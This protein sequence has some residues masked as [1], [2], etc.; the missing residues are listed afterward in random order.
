MFCK[1]AMSVP[2]LSF[3][4]EFPSAVPQQRSDAASRGRELQKLFCEVGG[5][6]R[7][8]LRIEEV[9]PH[10]I[11]DNQ[12]VRGFHSLLQGELKLADRQGRTVRILRIGIASE[13]ISLAKGPFHQPMAREEDDQRVRF[14]GGGRRPVPDCG[15]DR[16][17]GRVCAGKQPDVCGCNARGSQLFGK[18]RRITFGELK[19]LAARK[20]RVSGY[21]NDNRTGSCAGASGYRARRVLSESIAAD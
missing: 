5:S 4:R 11:G 20:S 12:H 15:F 18:G 19:L 1:R 8:D 14:S 13:E 9:A 21:A 7:L 3:A 10:R 17:G 2:T 16:R 6:K